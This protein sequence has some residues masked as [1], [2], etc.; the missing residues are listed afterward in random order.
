M[1]MK[2]KITLL[3]VLILIIIG[4]VV[5]V[6]VLVDAGS[7]EG[8]YFGSGLGAE[9]VYIEQTLTLKEDGSF[10]IKAYSPYISS[11]PYYLYGVYVVNGNYVTLTSGGGSGDR[12]TY[13][14]DKK[15]K[16]LRTN[17]G[18]VLKKK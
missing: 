12:V 4:I 18:L 13:T 10:V 7:I 15:N 8:T 9:N 3:V 16:T 1:T 17:V 2:G 14:W 6:V 11:Q 5:G